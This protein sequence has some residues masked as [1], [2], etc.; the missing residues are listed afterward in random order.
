M[1]RLRG[2]PRLT[3]WQKSTKLVKSIAMRPVAHRYNVLVDE[4]M[5]DVAR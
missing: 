5:L 4:D 1:L 3:P 2:L